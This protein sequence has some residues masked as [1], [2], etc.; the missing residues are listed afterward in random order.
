[1]VIERSGGFAVLGQITLTSSRYFELL[2]SPRHQY[3]ELFSANASFLPSKIG[4][5]GED[6]E[7]LL[8]SS[9]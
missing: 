5:T 2:I 6:L 4:V 8:S 9:G 3:F 7:P 1:M